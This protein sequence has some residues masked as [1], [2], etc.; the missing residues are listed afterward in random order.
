MVRVDWQWYHYTSLFFQCRFT[1]GQLSVN[2]WYPVGW[3][4]TNSWTT[5]FFSSSPKLLPA[6]SYSSQAITCTFETN[7]AAH[8]DK[9]L[10]SRFLPKN[11]GQYCEQATYN[12]RASYFIVSTSITTEKRAWWRFIINSQHHEKM[13]CF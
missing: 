7:M 2:C 10:I 12:C 4:Y 11:L 8:W 6:P 13:F 1:V 9:H 5:D 3:Q